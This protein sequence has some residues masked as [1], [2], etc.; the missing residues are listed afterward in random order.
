MGSLGG[1]VVS[2]CFFLLYGFLLT[3]FAFWL[4]LTKKFHYYRDRPERYT[5]QELERKSY[6]PQP[7]CYRFPLEPTLKILLSSMG[8]FVEAFMFASRD[9]NNVEHVSMG[10]YSPYDECGH[11]GE[12]AKLHH[13]T[14]YACF[15]VSGIVD[16]LSL[17]AD[18]PK[19]TSKLFFVFAFLAEGFL[20]HFHVEGRSLFNANAHVLLIYVIAGNIVFGL[21]RMYDSFNVLV[22]TGFAFCLTL[23]GSWFVQ[24][25]VFLYGKHPLNEDNDEM[26]SSAFMVASFIWHF[27]FLAIFDVVVYAILQAIIGRA[28]RGLTEFKVTPKSHLSS[29]VEIMLKEVVCDE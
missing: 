12:Q 15:A 16:L 19:H 8:M 2:G 25:G 11:L 7:I 14:M 6:I 1:H 26:S 21:L 13:L 29:E 3:L 17:F 9:E 27:M 23:Q 5:R 18:F 22:N 4:H 10:V 24:I 20:L 28:T